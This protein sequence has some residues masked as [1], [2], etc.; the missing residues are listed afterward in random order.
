MKLIAIFPVLTEEFETTIVFY[1][2]LQSYSPV[3]SYLAYYEEGAKLFSL[4]REASRC[5]GYVLGHLTPF[6]L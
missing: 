4:Y 6:N 3:F 5:D 2:A 1:L